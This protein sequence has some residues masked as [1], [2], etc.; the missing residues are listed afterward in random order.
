MSGGHRR[1]TI[2][3]MSVEQIAPL[4]VVVAGG[5]VAALEAVMALH[6]LGG[7]RLQLTL[8][9]PH[10]DILQIPAFLSRQ[11]DLLIAAAKTG[12]VAISWR[13]AIVARQIPAQAIAIANP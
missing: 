5:G 1:A 3:G 9:A 13:P 11:T 8:V 4:R 6:D 10:V 7:R 2:I 12:K